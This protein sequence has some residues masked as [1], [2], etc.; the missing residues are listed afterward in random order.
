MAFIITRRNLLKIG[1]TLPLW[2]LGAEHL[3]LEGGSPGPDAAPGLQEVLVPITLTGVS[4]PRTPR[5]DLWLRPGETLHL[6][7]EAPQKL[8][9]MAWELRLI[10]QVDFDPVLRSPYVFQLL[11]YLIDDALDQATTHH[12]TYSLLLEGTSEPRTQAAYM[13][14]LWNSGVRAGE[15]PLRVWAKKEAVEILPGGRVGIEVN[16]YR[17]RPQRRMDDISGPPDAT[18]FLDLGE[19]TSDWQQFRLPIPMDEGVACALFKIVGESYRGKVWL[20]DPRFLGSVGDSGAVEAGAGAPESEGIS[21][22]P[23]FTPANPFQPYRTWLGTNLSKKEWPEFRLTVNGKETFGGRLFQPEYPWP[24]TEVGIPAGLLR[25]GKNDL[26]IEL[27]RVYP[28]QHG[29]LL[30]EAQWL[31]T[32]GGRLEVVACPQLVEAGEEF[33]VLVRTRGA[34]IRMEVEVLSGSKGKVGSIAAVDSNVL[35]QEPGLHFLKFRAGRAGPGSRLRFRFGDEERSVAVERVVERPEDNVLVGS[36]DSQWFAYHQ[37][38]L[39]RFFAWHLGNSV[40]NFILFRPIYYEGQGTR[41]YDSE[42]WRFAVRMCK[43]AG[44]YYAFLQN[45]SELPELDSNPPPEILQSPLYL[46]SQEHELDGSYYY[47]AK[48]FRD[49]LRVWGRDFKN[50]FRLPELA[51]R[52][53]L[54]DRNPRKS[55]LPHP[56]DP[57][58]ASD[59]MLRYRW[60]S[61]YVAKN[62]REAAE[63]F[64]ENIKNVIPGG[65]RHCG[66]ATLFKYF[67]QAGNYKYQIGEMMYG[68]FEVVLG[69][70]RG[71]SHAY[72]QLGYGAHIA[73]QWSTTP[74]DDPAA[75]RRYFLAL[76]TCYLHGVREIYQEDCLSLIEYQVPVA[77]DRFSPACQGHLKVHQAFYRFTRAHSRRGRMRVPLGFLQGQYDGWNCWNNKEMVWGQAGEE[78]DAG[79]PEQS[80]DLLK[81]FLPRSV[82]A[83]IYRLPCPHEPVGFFTGTPYG[84]VDIVPIEAEAKYLGNYRSL[85]LVGWNTADAAQLDRLIE[86]VE[87]G[88]HLTL[89]L[90]HLS[91][92]LR[93]K[94][95]AQPLAA[96]QV[97]K[98]LGLEIRGFKASAGAYVGKEAG[99]EGLAKLLRGEVLQLGEV[100]VDEGV[101]RVSDGNGTPVLVEHE[102]GRGRVTFLNTAAYPGE[103]RVSPLYEE[104]LRGMGSESMGEER[105]RVW[106]RGNEDVSFAVWDWEGS[107]RGPGGTRTI[108][109]LNVNWWSEN[110]EA[111]QAQLLWREAEIPLAISRDKIHIVTVSGDW[112]IWVDDGETDIMRIEAEG[113]RARVRLQGQGKSPLQVLYRPQGMAAKRPELSGRV[114]KVPLRLEALPTPGL[115]RTELLLEGPAEVE[116]EAR[117]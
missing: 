71:S 18:H 67:F 86:Y 2:R 35:L 100:V 32:P 9:D 27:K 107:S 91:T 98:L 76:A 110:P 30:R 42:A 104:L 92:E 24:G 73:S 47:W 6:S 49:P 55:R 16:L 7:V 21:S 69:T 10:G 106:V 113:K 46:G 63:Y 95:P 112:G 44:I 72:G 34:G 23:P 28:E 56:S 66:P 84:P 105:Q 111:G 61:P 11:L 78:W 20:E 116:L 45:Q 99:D 14:V 82:L 96:P 4:G 79:P 109:L 58:L 1:S 60:C 22:L 102:L 36:G 74:H 25:P 37:E 57:R 17:K 80:W 40:G 101:V 8:R 5:G 59:T 54:F 13:R 93:R 3:W 39:Q 62:M 70:L 52:V 15:Y 115:W 87:K 29:Y 68:P 88:G 103:A 65:P 33:G 64:I 51:L 77:Q 26:T 83:P 81:T 94:Q 114:G 75:F 38:S 90:V 108:Y 97:R 117:G 43:E 53:D 19:G 41:Y 48:Q 50:T 89:G 12:Q 85:V 31:G